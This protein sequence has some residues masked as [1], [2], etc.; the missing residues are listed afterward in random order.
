M[1]KTAD[2]KAHITASESPV[3]TYEKRCSFVQRMRDA[4]P[5]LESVLNELQHEPLSSN[6]S[7]KVGE[8]CFKLGLREN[9]GYYFRK[10]MTSDPKNSDALNNM[11]VLCVERGEF[12]LAEQ[13][14]IMA[15]KNNPQNMFARNN[16][17][18]VYHGTDRKG[19]DNG[20]DHVR[21]P[22]CQGTFPL[23]LPFGKQNP[24]PN[25]LC[26]K[27]GSLER[28]RLLMLYLRGWTEFFSK[29]LRVLHLAPEPILQ[30]IFSGL[31]NI[32][33]VSTDLNSTR[34]MSHMDIMHIAFDDQIFDI[35][36]C[37]H[38]LEH[39]ADDRKALEEMLRVLKPGGY[40]ILQIPEK[41]GLEKSFEDASIVS[42]EDRQQ[43]F[44]QSDHVR[45]YGR[46]VTERLRSAGFL[47]EEWTLPHDQ[48]D[49][50]TEMY[51]LLPDDII[52]LCRRPDAESE[53]RNMK[54]YWNMCAQDNAMKHIAIHDW[55]NEAIFHRSG[56]ESVE[57]LLSL[58]DGSFFE[59]LPVHSRM[60][61][62][63]CGIG[64]MLKPI[65]MR[66]TD[67]DIYGI[68]ISEEMISQGR[69]RMKLFRNVTLLCNNGKD[70]S[71]FENDSYHFIYSYIVFQHIPRRYVRSYFR[72]V[73]RVL[74][75]TG[76]FAFQM[77]LLDTRNEAN[78]PPDNDFRSIRY[79]SNNEV[80]LLCSSNGLEIMHSHPVI[81]VNGYCWYVARKQNRNT[82][83]EKT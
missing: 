14:F 31:P 33:Y 57:V 29:S 10:A 16:L 63:G 55:E 53:V 65:A 12:S 19:I 8:L 35:I 41:R 13:Y 25:A 1:T 61:D 70:L 11:G 47:V 17:S 15:I 43:Y 48:E 32:F 30:D 50:Q 79:Y 42:P 56:Q 71:L 76:L 80:G 83:T 75:H 45:V 39:V 27:C 34:A 26:P 82:I 18:M 51:G 22:C 78:E 6:A 44:G 69:E 77:Q 52:Y 81:P 23:F 72:E 68:D 3:T 60:L 73:N 20:R 28:H 62:I 24:R 54:T 49:I 7:V 21:C 9:A 46:D 66:F 58:V 64:R 37:S 67:M 74:D 36:I 38:V 2:K 40:V 59:S 4:F 5:S